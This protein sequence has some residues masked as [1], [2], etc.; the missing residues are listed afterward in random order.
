MGE[1]FMDVDDS[2]M[3]F[4]SD[5]SSTTKSMSFGPSTMTNRYDGDAASDS[6]QNIH[7][8]SIG[9]DYCAASDIT[10]GKGPDMSSS[11]TSSGVATG[12]IRNDGS[13]V[14]GGQATAAARQH[15][16]ALRSLGPFSYSALQNAPSTL[17]GEL[18]T[19]AGKVC[20]DNDAC[21]HGRSKGAPVPPDARGYIL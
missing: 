15:T 1:Y 7:S 5:S 9:S 3:P 12:F 13:Y 19:T 6:D 10:R 8:K 20:P 18:S 21:D 2:A 4:I 17:S 14:H 11:T 16:R